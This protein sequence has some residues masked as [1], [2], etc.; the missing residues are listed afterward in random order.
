MTHHNFWFSQIAKLR[1]SI[2]YFDISKNYSMKNICSTAAESCIT[3]HSGFA[4]RQ[5]RKFAMGHLMKFLYSQRTN[6]DVPQTDRKSNE[7][8]FYLLYEKNILKWSK[9]FGKMFANMFFAPKSVHERIIRERTVKRRQR[10][11]RK[12]GQLYS[13]VYG[14]S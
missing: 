2:W 1:S 10:N 8:I 14:M 7:E 5:N 4:I 3:I 9:K 12:F 11:Q 13:K 6:L